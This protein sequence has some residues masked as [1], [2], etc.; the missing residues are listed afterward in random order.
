M[1]GLMTHEG[2]LQLGG[3]CMDAR[4]DAG[5]AQGLFEMDWGGG[6]GGA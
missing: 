2:A 5:A 1:D 6:G 4:M 3:R